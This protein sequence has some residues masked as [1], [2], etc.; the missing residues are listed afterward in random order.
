MSSRVSIA[1]ALIALVLATRPA[2]ALDADTKTKDLVHTKWSGVRINPE[3]VRLPIVD[4]VDNRFVRLSTAQGVSQIKVDQ[5]VQ[6]NDG[7]MWFG[8]RY[9]LYRYDG[10]SFKVFVREHGNPNSLDGVV[11]NALFKGRDGALWVGCDEF[12]NK[13]DRTTETFRHYRVPYATHITEDTAG[14]LWVASRN[15]LYHL[16]PV[17]GQIQHYTSDPHDPSSLSGND[18]SYCEEDRRG[19]FWIASS[20]YLDEFDR[21]TGKVTRHI[22]I[23]ETAYGFGFYEDRFGVFWIFHSS[24]NPLATLDRETN[25]LTHYA[26]PEREPTVMRISAVLEDQTGALWMATHGLGL[27]KLDREH[28]RFLDYTN[29]STDPESLPQNK[30]DALYV[31]RAG[32]IWAAPGRVAPAFLASKPPPF[33]RLPKTPGST[34]EPFVGALY[35]DR[36]GILWIGTP[37]ALNRLDRKTGSTIAYTTGGPA[38]GTDVVSICEDRSGYLW[39]GTYSH[40]LHRFDPRTGKFKTYRHNSADLYTLSNDFVMALLIDQKG[41]LWAAT[42]DG[43][44]RFDSTTE[45]FTVYKPDPRGTAFYRAIVEDQERCGSAQNHQVFDSSIPRRGSRLFTKTT[46]TFRGL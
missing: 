22:S 6:D 10:Y 29:V 46:A 44:N 25:T 18:L 16:D 5:I 15:G 37:E 4:S 36:E 32:D 20:G 1:I 17:S 30:V 40:G 39:I 43:L 41:A 27:L 38:V 45:R 42:G 28:G 3:A 33:R 24:P 19:A 35:E 34:I 21:K 7:F 8:T 14:I 13:F 26:F 9:G 31:D 2:T 23:P 11:I 12:L